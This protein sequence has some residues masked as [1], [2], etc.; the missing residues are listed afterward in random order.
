MRDVAPALTT[1]FAPAIMQNHENYQEKST[2][3]KQCV[4]ERHIV[5]EE[6][7]EFKD[8]EVLTNNSLSWNSHIDMVSAKANKMPGLIKSICKDL[9][10]TTNLKTLYCSLDRSNLEYCSAVWSPFTQ[11]NIDKLERIQRRVTKFVL[12]S[13]DVLLS[14]LK[15]LTLNKGPF[16]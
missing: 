15:L 9:K 16:I 5:L 13:N 12:K 6:V 14:R 3:N 8:L 4:Y 1:I 11:R 7:M 10:D 2:L